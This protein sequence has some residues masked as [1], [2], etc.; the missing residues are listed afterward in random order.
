MK[1]LLCLLFT[2]IVVLYNFTS[3]KN[4]NAALLYPPDACDSINV[5]Y[6]G[7]IL[8]ILRD[9]CYRCHAG[10]STVGPFNLDSYDDV[11][12]HAQDESL[13]KAVSHADGFSPM[14]KDASQLSTCNLAKIR[15]WLDD[16]Y[17]NN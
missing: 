14:P 15:R 5:T 11:R 9:N 13:W 3:C 7:T 12:I 8:P 1:K 4:D 17:P 16:G 10:S 2:V 6:S